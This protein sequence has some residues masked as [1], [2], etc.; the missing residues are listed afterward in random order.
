MDLVLI[1]NMLLANEYNQIAEINEDGKLN[2]L[3]IVKYF[4]IILNT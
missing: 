3:D 1:V 4:N 2:I